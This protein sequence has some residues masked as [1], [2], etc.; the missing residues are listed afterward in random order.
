MKHMMALSNCVSGV[1]TVVHELDGEYERPS[2]E[3]ATLLEGVSP[4]K[5]FVIFL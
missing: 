3:L 5:K 2:R 1:H 4:E